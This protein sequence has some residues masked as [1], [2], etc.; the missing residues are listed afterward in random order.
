M[1]KFACLNDRRCGRLE[2]HPVQVRHKQDWGRRVYPF[3]TPDC[4]TA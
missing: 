1:G 2:G 3:T 4:C